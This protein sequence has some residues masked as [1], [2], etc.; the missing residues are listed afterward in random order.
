[1]P[2]V[3]DAST[4][5]GFYFALKGGGGR[6]VP[7]APDHR[8]SVLVEPGTYWVWAPDG[9]GDWIQSEVEVPPGAELQLDVAR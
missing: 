1:V 5:S 6:W 7:A 9:E 8:F 3:G 2:G 4:S